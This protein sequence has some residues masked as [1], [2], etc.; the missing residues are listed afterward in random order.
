MVELLIALLVASVIASSVYFVFQSQNRIFYMQESIAQ[1]QSDLRFAMESIKADVKR[2]GFLAA[3]NTANDNFYCGS[4]PNPPITALQHTDGG[5]FVFLPTQNVNV[6]P[7]QLRILG[8]FNVSDTWYT[9]QVQGTVITISNAPALSPG[10]PTTQTDFDRVLSTGSLLRIL[11]TTNRYQIQRITS[12]NFVSRS[13]TLQ[14]VTQ[15][16]VASCGPRGLGEGNVVNPLEY[17]RYRIIDTSNSANPALCANSGAMLGRS[18]LVRED[19]A[20]DGVTVLNTLPIADYIVDL[21]FSFNIDTAPLGNQPAIAA[22]PNP[23][24]FEG[25]ATSAQANANPDQIRSVGI[26]LSGRTPQEDPGFAFRPRVTFQFNGKQSFGP[27]TSFNLDTDITN[28]CRVRS[29]SSE[30]QLRNFGLLQRM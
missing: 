29:L 12:S 1:V 10:F 26:Q 17:V 13:V 9:T 11:D 27:L 25:N 4:R 28:S 18:T 22:D 24:D 5:G 6:D 7:D 16:P 20:P 30:V 2:A 21:Q 15:S 19:L 14:A 23:Y 3:L 8:A